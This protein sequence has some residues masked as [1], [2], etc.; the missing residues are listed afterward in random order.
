MLNLEQANEGMC[1]F[2]LKA[3][4]TGQG[5]SVLDRVNG[6]PEGAHAAN[7][8]KNGPLHPNTG[9]Q[10]CVATCSI[11]GLKALKIGHVPGGF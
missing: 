4:N 7:S 8:S 10:T 1:H 5:Q 2:R 6:H 11:I 9:R 3:T